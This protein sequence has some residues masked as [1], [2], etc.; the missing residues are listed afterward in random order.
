MRWIWLILG[1]LLVLSGAT[2]TLQGIGVLGG[3]S[4]TGE[5]MWAIIGPIVTIVGLALIW[6]GVGKPGAS[7]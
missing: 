2:W 7:K 5:T 1:I 6:R 3:S 4:M